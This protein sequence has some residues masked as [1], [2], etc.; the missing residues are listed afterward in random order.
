MLGHLKKTFLY[1]FQ[2][3][4]NLE[5]MGLGE[6]FSAIIQDA[7]LTFIS[8]AY[9]RFIQGETEEQEG[10]AA[11]EL[12]FKLESFKN[13]HNHEIKEKRIDQ[14][15]H[16]LIKEID[17]NKGRMKTIADIKDYINEKFN[18]NFSYVQIQYQVKKLIEEN[19]GRPEDDATLLIEEFEKD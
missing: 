19:F 16:E 11:K 9:P 15:T 1:I 8:S 12:K 6:P 10:N 4:L 2:M 3:D 7:N 13:E 17:S 18:S 14:F 5:R